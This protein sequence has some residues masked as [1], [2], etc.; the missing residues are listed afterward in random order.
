[1]LGV[2]ITAPCA[3]VLLL[4]REVPPRTAIE[5]EDGLATEQ[6]FVQVR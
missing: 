2:P 4:V 5:R 3:L 1:M 6:E